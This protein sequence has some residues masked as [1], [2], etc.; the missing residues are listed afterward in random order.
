MS[1]KVKNIKKEDISKKNKVVKTKVDHLSRATYIVPIVF[2]VAECILMFV[3]LFWYA[4]APVL[5][6]APLTEEEISQG[7]SFM[8]KV[9]KNYPNYIVNTVLVVI[10]FLDIFI[11]GIWTTTYIYKKAYNKQHINLA[12][13]ICALIFFNIVVGILA[14]I[15]SKKV[16]LTQSSIRHTAK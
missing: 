8:D 2:C 16:P 7:M 12:W 15:Y 13:A 3:L 9:L 5:A 6:T 11:F 10:F 4:F 14:I 1:K